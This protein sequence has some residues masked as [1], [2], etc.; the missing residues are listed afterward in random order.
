MALLEV[1]KLAVHMPTARGAVPLVRQVDFS[2]ER[3]ET[4]GIVG[5][6]GCGKTMTAL[7]LMGLLPDLA[8][9]SGRVLFDGE[10]L[11]SAPESRLCT[12]RGNRLAM[13]FQEPMSA[14]NPVHPIG[15]QIAESLILHRGISQSDAMAEAVRLLDLVRLP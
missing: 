8:V 1:D 12:L 11:V 14:L 10:D 6:S 13:I 15:A 4:L 9:P 5:E 7:A 2:I 3:G